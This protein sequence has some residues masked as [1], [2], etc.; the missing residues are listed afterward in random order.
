MAVVNAEEMNGRD[1]AGGSG[2][3]SGTTADVI[4]RT[5][6]ESRNNCHGVLHLFPSPNHRSV[7]P[8]HSLVTP[9]DALLPHRRRLAVTESRA[10]QRRRRE[11]RLGDRGRRNLAGATT[12]RGNVAGAVE[13]PEILGAECGGND[14]AGAG[15]RELRVESF[16]WVVLL[17]SSAVS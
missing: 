15:G 17:H 6:H 9:S 7:S 2:A 13:V 1:L 16:E 5:R 12:D 10:V 8:T 14:G 4:A 11:Y 3:G